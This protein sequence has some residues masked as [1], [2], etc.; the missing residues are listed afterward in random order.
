[1]AKKMRKVIAG[2]LSA[3]I[4]TT[5]L[6]SGAMTANAESS[7]GV[8]LSAHA[9]RAYREGWSYVW[10]GTLYG[11]VDCSGLIWTYNGVGGCRVDMLAC[12]SEW[13]YVSSGV[14]NIHGLGLHTPGHVGVYIGSGMAVDARNEYWGVV[15]HNV[16]NA[17]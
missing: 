12:A 5:M 6:L 17:I 3:S 11:A 1:M 2:A 7:T 4:I 9:L 15:Y 10:G 8:G 14:P 16:Y 13:G